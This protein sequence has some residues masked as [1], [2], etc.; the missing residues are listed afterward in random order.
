[1]QDIARS[2]FSN[3]SLVYFIKYLR[4]KLVSILYNGWKRNIFQLILRCQNYH[5]GKTK[6][7]VKKNTRDQIKKVFHKILV[8]QTC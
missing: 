1:M 2:C 4:T 8:K 6:D 7:V 5:D 3:R